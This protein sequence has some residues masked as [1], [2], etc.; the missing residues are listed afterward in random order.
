ML[1]SESRKHLQWKLI[2]KQNFCSWYLWHYL[3][4]TGL[5]PTYRTALRFTNAEWKWQPQN[6]SDHWSSML[7]LQLLIMKMLFEKLSFNATSALLHSYGGA[8]LYRKSRH[9]LSKEKKWKYHERK[10]QTCT[11]KL[12]QINRKWKLGLP[13][14][15]R[16]GCT[17]YL[18]SLGVLQCVECLP[19]KLSAI[20]V[21]R[22][23]TNTKAVGNAVPRE[24]SQIDGSPFRHT[25][26]R[27]ISKR[28]T[29]KRKL[30][31]WSI[32]SGW[33]LVPT[34]EKRRR[35]NRF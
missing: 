19:S 6:D 34:T 7:L 2:T 16:R 4:S 33:K 13:A 18:H 20:V 10:W 24:I 11:T 17:L 31:C 3:Y 21:H 32:R 29:R 9:L 28:M 22:W 30:W 5:K 27:N 35:M 8:S 1:L 26:K 12:F 15:M 14:W 25:S 23:E